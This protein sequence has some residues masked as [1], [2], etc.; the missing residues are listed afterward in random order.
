MS[1]LPGAILIVLWTSVHCA[2]KGT[3]D[4]VPKSSLC[5]FDNLSLRGQI[6][7]EKAK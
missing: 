6:T 3:C 5:F 2:V 7:D 4:Q 1:S